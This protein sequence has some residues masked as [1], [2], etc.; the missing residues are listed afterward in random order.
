MTTDLRPPPGY[1]P[2]DPP[3]LGP[4]G[5]LV[6]RVEETVIARPL[7]EVVAAVD[8]ARL[9]DWID[10]S[11]SLPGVR[12]TCMLRG[13][14]FDAPGSRHMVFLTDGTTVVE[15]V[16]DKHR[17]PDGYGFRYQVWDYSTPAAKPLRYGLGAFA[18][19]PLEGGNT[20]ARWTYAFELRP[21]RFPGLLG[22]RL[23]GWLLKKALLDGAY[24]Q[25]MRG[26]LA[27]L[28]AIAER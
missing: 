4:P 18:Y 15:Q 17:G 7:S 28:K 9:E 16:L 27:R 19:T 3:P 10:G 14:R 11:G 8:A 25:W 26:S 5:H 20:R 13:E 12:G 22:P 6:S 2:S 23:G 1:A 24:A 21:D